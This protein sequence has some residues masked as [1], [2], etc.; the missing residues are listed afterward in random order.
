MVLPLSFVKLPIFTKSIELKL[1]I[2]LLRFT[3]VLELSRVKLKYVGKFGCFW[4]I[5]KE[6][7]S[8]SIN[9]F[10]ILLDF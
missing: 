9:I 2:S 1:T 10:K 5:S 8:F 4:L 6:N 7:K 3:K